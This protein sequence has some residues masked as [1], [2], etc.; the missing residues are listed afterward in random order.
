MDTAQIEQVPFNADMI[1]AQVMKTYPQ[2][3]IVFL[4]HRTACVGCLMSRFDSLA[5][6]SEN[7]GIPIENLLHE[8]TRSMQFT[9]NARND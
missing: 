7:Y 6:V 1:V 3:I 8:L 9:G 2:T 5:D 4:Q